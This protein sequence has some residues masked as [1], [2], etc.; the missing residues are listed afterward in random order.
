[1]T[2]LYLLVLCLVSTLIPYAHAATAYAPNHF[3][4]TCLTDDWVASVEAS[5][6]ISAMARDTLGRRVNPYLSKALK[7]PRFTV[8]D[9]RTAD[10]NTHSPKCTPAGEVLYGVGATV[11]PNDAFSVTN[12]G[13]VNGSL[14]LEL[15]GWTSHSIT[16]IVFAIL[17]SEVYGVPV[18]LYYAT[19]TLALTQRMS[20]VRAGACTPT[21][22]NLEVW[23]AGI[24]A[25]LQ[26]YA[27]ESYP[28]GALGY[29]GRSGLYTTADFVTDMAN[30]T[31]HANPLY[32]DFWKGY[33]LNDDL[34][35]QVPVSA[36]RNNSA[37]FPPAELGCANGS[38]G[39]LN[40]CSKT[41]ACTQR[42][43]QHKECLVVA[44]MYDYFDPGYLQAVLANNGVPAYFCF[45]G[46]SGTQDYALAMQKRRQPVLFY[47]YEPDLFHFQN[48]GLFSR[49][50]LPRSVPERV[51]LATGLFGEN[52]YGNAT[53]NPVDVDFPTTRLTKYAASVLQNQFPMGSLVGKFALQ[54]LD[55]NDLLRKYLASSQDANEPDPTFRAACNWVK[56]NYATWSLWL[57]RLPL[58][59]FESHIKYSISGCDDAAATERV[60]TFEWRQPSP[61]D[62]SL[63]YNCD[64]GLAELPPPLHTSRTCS[65]LLADEARWRSWVLTRPECDSSFYK[66]NITAC[67]SSA[68]RLVRFWWL[69]PDPADPTKSLECR[70]GVALPK[71]VKI[72]CEY[73]PWTSPTF[74]VISAIAGVLICVLV[75][76]IVFVTYHRHKPI[77]KRSQFELL[78]LM[79]LGGITVCIAAVLYAGRPTKVLCAA[80]PLTIAAGFTVIFGSLFV[81]SL[82]VYRVFMRSALKRV[83]VTISMM[84][85]IFALF[86]AVDVLILGAWFIADFPE[87]TV[88]IKA[89]KDFRGDVDHVVC[90]SASFIFTALLMFWKAIVLLLGLYLS[91]LIRNVSADFQESIWIFGSSLMVLIGCLVILPLAYL[92][93]MAAAIFYIFLSIALL[94]C[95][96]AVMA[97]MLVPKMLRLN[98]VAKGRYSSSTAAGG[99][100]IGGTTMSRRGSVEDDSNGTNVRN[101]RVMQRGSGVDSSSTRLGSTIVKPMRDATESER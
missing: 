50:F 93:E 4:G 73:M 43:A 21:H 31:K 55:I 17:A 68:K 91:F 5:L 67:D 35:A 24:E 66:Y 8:A 45:L 88:V 98:E 27:N 11:D 38:F 34:I 29:V 30:A 74:G 75:L 37:A 54:D 9:P 33:K 86:V 60:L 3:L 12:R 76:A 82:R 42:E 72:E 97:M 32:A 99:T 63:P 46:Y 26:V 19:N 100:T 49:V 41:L 71:S 16:T 84:L 10:P 77:I 6:K 14:V 78:V 58:C 79:I 94:V 2:S 57:D 47:H 56:Q 23:I 48:P 92:V 7:T 59:T 51:V 87:P 69:L 1:M 64:G 36:L 13:V 44:M 90:K 20:S 22:L 52:G 89:S 25:A 65:W 101:V 81:K 18:S 95:T 96:A 62:A 28:A 61:E 85:K 15:S 80:R 39:C 83:T 53:D 70:G 40:H